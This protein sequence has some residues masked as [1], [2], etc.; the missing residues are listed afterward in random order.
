MCTCR[1]D[2]VGVDLDQDD[3]SVFYQAIAL[4]NNTSFPWDETRITALSN[5]YKNSRTANTAVYECRTNQVSIV[6]SL[7]TLTTD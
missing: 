5:R 1:L 2:E 7:E 3:L 4:L 6:V